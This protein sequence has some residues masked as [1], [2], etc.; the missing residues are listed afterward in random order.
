MRAHAAR[1]KIDTLQ[2]GLGRA[3][4]ARSGHLGGAALHE[5]ATALGTVEAGLTWLSALPPPSVLASE[6]SLVAVLGSS[7]ASWGRTLSTEAVFTVSGS[8]ATPRSRAAVTLVSQLS[9]ARLSR[10]LAIHENW[11][12]PI[13]VVVYGR[14]CR[15]ALPRAHTCVRG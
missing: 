15:S 14:R 10:V 2:N 7:F 3:E 13:S 8:A 1:D 6:P 5:S 12:G 11:G 4:D 9:V